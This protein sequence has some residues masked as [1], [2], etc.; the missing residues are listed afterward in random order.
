MVKKLGN[1]LPVLI[2]IFI[3]GCAVGTQFVRPEPESLKNGETKY[4][5]IIERFGFTSREG[6]V[7]KN[8]KS[9]KTL[10]Y[11][12]LPAPAGSA[13]FRGLGFYFLNDVLVGY[14]FT[15]SAA[16]DHTDFDETKI[17]QIIKGKSTRAAVIA[18]LGRPGGYYNYPMIKSQSGEAAV[19]KYSKVT[20]GFLTPSI[21]LKSLVVTFDTSG[22]VADVEFSSSA[23]R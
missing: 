12:Y 21:L 13:G 8:E 17:N 18:L 1:L 10:S 4:S 9:V 14:E 19:Y 7:V 2:A 16:E 22:I 6:T 5:Q 3:S 15:S 11:T 23:T 20:T